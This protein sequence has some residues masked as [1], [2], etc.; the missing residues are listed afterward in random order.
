MSTVPNFKDIAW[1]GGPRSMARLADWQAAAG[2]RLEG[3]GGPTPELITINP[4]YSSADLQGLEHLH[5]M[6][7]FPPFVRGPYHTM[8]PGRPWTVQSR[9]GDRMGRSSRGRGNRQA[10]PPTYPPACL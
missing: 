5:T 2:G 8:Y 1:E 6:P 7:G 3:L 10:A 9:R 4:L